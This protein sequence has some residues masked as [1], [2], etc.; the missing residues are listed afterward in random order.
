MFMSCSLHFTPL[1]GS[2]NSLLAVHSRSFTSFAFCTCSLPDNHSQSLLIVYILN[3]GAPRTYPCIHSLTIGLVS[4]NFV[5]TNTGRHIVYSVRYAQIEFANSIQEPSQQLKD[6][7]CSPHSYFWLSP[8]RTKIPF[9]WLWLWLDNSQNTPKYRLF[10]ISGHFSTSRIWKKP[11]VWHLLQFRAQKHVKKS[12][13]SQF[14]GK[15]PIFVN[16]I[17]FYSILFNFIQFL[18]PKINKKC[19][20]IVSFG[21]IRVFQANSHSNQGKMATSDPLLPPKTVLPPVFSGFWR[22]FN[23]SRQNPTQKSKNAIF[24]PENHFFDPQNQ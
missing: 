13:C 21:H 14:L 7:N 23:F 9:V 3:V 12:I 2:H 17:Q 24:D 6:P 4:R 22:F 20:F 19:H 1:L 16:F 11:F 18:T 10:G 8:K 15:T 5:T